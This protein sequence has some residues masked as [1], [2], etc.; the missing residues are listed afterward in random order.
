MSYGKELIIDL[1]KCRRSFDRKTV[2]RF[3]VE[4]CDLLEMERADLHYWDYE[5]DEEKAEA[6]D[7][8]AGTS[9]VQFITTSNITVHTLDKLGTVY[10]NIFTCGELKKEAV[11]IF[12]REFWKGKVAQSLMVKRL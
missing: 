12:C 2:G 8:L 4:V 3:M 5:T 10:L 11:E 1:H 7:H 6:P 9:A